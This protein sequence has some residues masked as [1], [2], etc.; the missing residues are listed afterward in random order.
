[1]ELLA[2][3]LGLLVIEDQSDTWAHGVD[4]FSHELGRPRLVES[5]V[6]E[7]G[8]LRTVHRQKGVWGNSEIWLDIVHNPTAG[9]IELLIRLNWQEKRQLLKL[10]IPSSLSD[11]RVVCRSAGGVSARPFAGDEQPCHDWVALVGKAGGTEVSVAIL[12]EGSYSF[13]CVDANLRMIVVRSTPYAEYAPIIHVT[14][15]SGDFTT[16]SHERS[17]DDAVAPHTDHGWQERRFAL[18]ERS[19]PDALGRLDREAEEFQVRPV[20]MIDSAHPGDLPWEQS[21]LLVEPGTVAV[22]AVKLAENGKGFIVRLQEMSGR[23]TRATLTIGGETPLKP[24]ALKP[25]EIKTLR[26]RLTRKGWTVTGTDFLEM[27][28]R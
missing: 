7:F 22:L 2:A 19:G 16:L 14:D 26:L 25:W 23:A 28:K 8:P 21:H 17:P 20:V 4:G 5:R 9:T 15:E 3:P 13:S 24:V 12:N 11:P 6:V 10:D 1:V 27:E 18:V